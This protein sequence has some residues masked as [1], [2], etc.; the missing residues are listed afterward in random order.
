MIRAR[1]EGKLAFLKEGMVSSSNCLDVTRGPGND[2]GIVSS[3]SVSI[4]MY[5]ATVQW[6]RIGQM[7]SVSVPIRTM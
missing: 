1:L 5:H 6:Y 4:I 2:E 3:L 7:F